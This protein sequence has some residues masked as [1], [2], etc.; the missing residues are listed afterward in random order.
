MNPDLFEQE[1]MEVG[2]PLDADD[3]RAMNPDLF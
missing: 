3:P 1:R 2:E